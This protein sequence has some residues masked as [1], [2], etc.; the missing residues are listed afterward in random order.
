MA[1]QDNRAWAEAK[2]L[3]QSFAD[4]ER[5]I[6]LTTDGGAQSPW[7]LRA[8]A[9]IGGTDALERFDTWRAPEER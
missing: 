1:P 8:C 2:R 5:R 6:Y 3:E 7:L 9:L 4:A